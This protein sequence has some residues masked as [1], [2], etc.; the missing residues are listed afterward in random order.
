MSA[1]ENSALA[2]RV[3]DAFNSRDYTAA[4]ALASDDVELLIVP[5]N[6]RFNGKA[7]FDAFMRGFVAGFSNVS[8]QLTNQVAC[9]QQ[10]VSEF[11]ARGTHDG[12]LLT[13]NGSLAATGRV[14][15]YPVIEVWRVRDGRLATLYNYFDA[16]TVLR[17][18]GLM[19]YE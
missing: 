14:V 2:R 10:V 7:G 8:I 13:P 4:L 11:I 15:E 9:D 5:F 18:L 6:Q 12:A 19:P 17:Q 3:Y 1:Q 16:A